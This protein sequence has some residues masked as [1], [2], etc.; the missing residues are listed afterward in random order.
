MFVHVVTPPLSVLLICVAVLRDVTSL[1]VH[2]STAITDSTPFRNAERQCF[3]LPTTAAVLRSRHR[4][5]AGRDAGSGYYQRFY[6]H[7]HPSQLV[8]PPVSRTSIR[9]VQRPYLG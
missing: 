1:A 2:S 5:H 9:A 7:S 6:V 3:R 8:Q 4:R